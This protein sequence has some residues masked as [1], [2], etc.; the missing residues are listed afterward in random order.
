MGKSKRM[1]RTATS[2]PD[3]LTTGQRD[4]AALRLRCQQIHQVANTSR[5]PSTCSS[6]VVGSQ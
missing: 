2:S 3:S 6:P 4:I 1:R 5:F